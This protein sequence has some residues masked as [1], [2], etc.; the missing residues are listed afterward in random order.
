[1]LSL[2]ELGS[3]V[4]TRRGEASSTLARINP[5]RLRAVHAVSNRWGRSSDA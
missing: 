5:V 1:M 3:G 4:P 2:R